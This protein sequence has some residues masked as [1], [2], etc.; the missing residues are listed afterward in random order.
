MSKTWSE[1]SEE[2]QLAAYAKVKAIYDYAGNPEWLK[3][4]ETVGIIALN[5]VSGKTKEYPASLSI[6]GN[7]PISERALVNDIT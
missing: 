5:L 3:D 6:I 4:T 1:H 2:E 7:A